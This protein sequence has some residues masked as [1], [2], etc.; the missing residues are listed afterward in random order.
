MR[1][2][3]F[4]CVSLLLFCSAGC[5]RSVAVGHDSDSTSTTPPLSSAEVWTD[6]LLQGMTLEEK[7]GQLFMPAVYSRLEDADEEMLRFYADSCHVGGL[8]LLKG[9]AESAATVA[10]VMTAYSDIAPWIAIDAEWGL[11][12]RITDA[13]RYPRNGRMDE[14]ADQTDLFDYG[15]E[16]ARECRVLGIN[17]VM[18]P[19]ADVA[20]EGSFIGSRSFGN[21]P[22]RVA[23]L[24]TAYA[25]GLES[26]GMVSVAKHFP[27]HGRGG[28]DS[29]KEVP[30]IIIDRDSLERTDLYPFRRYADA[31]LSGIM[32]GHISV[33]ALDASGLPATV[34]RLMLTELLR[35]DIGFRGLVITDALNMRGAAGYRAADAIAAGADIVVAP[36]STSDEIR[37]IIKRVDSGELDECVIDDRCARVLRQKYS[38]RVAG[39]LRR[40]IRSPRGERLRSV[41]SFGTDSLQQ[42]LAPR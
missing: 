26:G 28:A 9:D 35:N 32:A 36:A 12:M 38:H 13:P 17:M 16:M 24:V 42:R 41:L 18:G 19:V 37:E 40:R 20:S 21:D 11:G 1:S 27:G 2:F 3:F 5:G 23:D 22:Q 31:G 6:S 14:D 7:V 25:S 33:P 15:E 30:V 4:L 34:S 39:P 29:H 8:L 10:S